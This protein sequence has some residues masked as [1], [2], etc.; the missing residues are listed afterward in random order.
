M[1]T[2]ADATATDNCSVA[3]IVQTDGPASGSTFPPGIT[4]VEYTATDA[5]GNTA[6]CSFNVIVNDTEDPVITCPADVDF[7]I[8]GGACSGIL[9]YPAPVISDNCPGASF[10]VL[11]GPADGDVV[12]TGVYTIELQAEDAAGNTANCSFTATVSETSAPVIDCPADTTVS[13]DPGVCTAVVTFMLPLASDSCSNV[14]VTQTGGPA[15]G[16]AFP[17]GSTSVEFTATDDFGNTATCSY[18]ITVNDEE[19]PVITCPGDITVSNDPGICGA[20]V[21]FADATATDNC[22]LASIVQTEGPASGS[23]FPVGTTSV[24]YT[25]TDASG[26]TAICSF[27][28]IV[29]D[30][31]DPIITCPADVDFTIPGGACS[32]ILNY[33]APVI[34]DNCPG[35][36]FT[37]LS[38]PADGDLVPAGVYTIE[39]Q[40]EDAAGNTAICS[41]IA[42]VSETSAPVIDCPADQTVPADPGTCSAV[43]NFPLP[44]ATD[45]CSSVTVTQTGGPSSGSTFPAGPTTVE[46]TATDAFGNS[47]TC[48]YVI[49][50]VDALDP[51]ITCPGDIAATT[52]P[53]VCE[54]I[55]TYD[56]PTA[57]DNCSLASVIMTEGLASGSAFPSGETTVTY[58]ATDISGNTASCSFTVTVTDNEAPVITCPAD[59]TVNIPDG[60]CS[61]VVNYSMPT[62]TDNC[63][64]DSLNL[65]EGLASGETFPTGTT[66]VT[67]EAIDPSGNTASCSFTV[68]VLETVP[69]EITCPADISLPADDGICGAVVNYTPPVGTDACPGATTVLTSGLG[70]GATFPVGVSTE[71]YTVTDASGNSVS[72]SFT[73]TISDQQAPIITCPADINVDADPGICSTVVNFN[74]PTVSDN[75]DASVIPVQTAGPTSGSPFPVGTTTITFTATDI[76]GNESNCSFDVVVSDTE[77][78]TI[79]CPGDIVVDAPSGDCQTVVTFADPVANDNCSGVTVSFIEGLVSGSDFPVGITTVT[80]EAAD[81][82]GNT[83]QCS[84][85]V[86]VNED[87]PPTIDCPANISVGSDIGECGAIVNYTAPVGVDNCGDATTE[88][89]GGL[90]PGSL[91]PVGT[92][93]VT[94]QVTDFSGNQTSCSFDV[95]VS[96]TEMPT[97]DCP[98]DQTLEAADGLCGIVYDFTL[99]TATDNCTADLVVNQSV[100]PATGSILPL[101]DTDFEFTTTDDAGNMS[102]C[103]YTVTVQDTQSP[104]FEICPGDTTIAVG[105]DACDALIS[106]TEPQAIDNCNFTLE[107]TGGPANNSSQGPGTY[108]FEYT[109]TDDSN[110]SS[111]CSFTFT[112]VDTI[113]PTI[114]CPDD[115]ETCSNMPEFEL[116]I[117]S[118]NCTV[119]EVVQTSGPA[120]GSVFPIGVTTIEFQATDVN[121][122]STVCELNIT[123]L[124]NAPRVD[125]GSDQNICG[126]TSTTLYGTDPGGA[127]PTWSQISGTGTI[128]NP[129]NAQ[130]GVSNLATGDNTFV[131]SLDPQNGCEIKSD[132]IMITVEPGVSVDAGDDQLI[133]NGGNVSLNAQVEPPGGDI[134]WSPE[135]GLSCITCPN[136]VASPGITTM[137]FVTYTSELG[138]EVTDSLTVRVFDQ[139]PNTITPDGDGTNDVWHIPGIEKYPNVVVIIY[140][141]WGNEVYQSTGY[142]DP[143]DGTNNGKE[144]P[145]G[146]YFYLIDYKTTGKENLNGTVNIIR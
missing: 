23:T 25:A 141:R 33:P 62:A 88:L 42:T 108:S 50:V 59:I 129:N 116:P 143:W 123:V 82:S 30:T 58:E 46:F 134:L 7:T 29:N 138:C 51:E 128:A 71:T 110:N 115:F 31:E 36:D 101:G 97:F 76:T 43:V 139:L 73:I 54:A 48:S 93:T 20:V 124:E 53:G 146:S 26:N 80:Y 15:S 111:T 83:A 52:D 114:T 69:P 22:A 64:I 21:T 130:T 85:T 6:V 136:P 12:S 126:E 125:L 24:E 107:Q 60:D 102:T 2:F 87:V 96:D 112:V 55:V 135:T 118:D 75:C 78:P 44:A 103:G 41:F 95:T 120:S 131:Y 16:S 1:V 14:T 32:G 67:Y 100:G 142:H 19:A 5:S 145:T 90:A 47:S 79:T 61:A 49:T 122:N 121:G 3:S 137:Y 68:S 127:T 56:A 144:L 35:A 27:N 91:F 99:P 40:A 72:C 104:V 38:G 17:E 9:N 117:A 92:T 65:I 106:F 133:F 45:S 94:Y 39:L 18:T 70:S 77:A 4:S 34:S 13:A 57:T 11:S 81:A 66:T 37:V 10:T 63:G 113:A 8:P 140:N 119:A 105:A 86:T 109:A 84:F 98:G 132:T 28:V 74:P 89:I